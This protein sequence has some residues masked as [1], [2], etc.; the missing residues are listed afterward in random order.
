MFWPLYRSPISQ[1]R[2]FFATERLA[3]SPYSLASCQNEE[4][5]V[6][7]IHCLKPAYQTFKTA[8]FLVLI[9]TSGGFMPLKNMQNSVMTHDII[10]VLKN[11]PYN[12]TILFSLQFCSPIACL[13]RQ[14]L[15]KYLT[16]KWY[17]F[18]FS[19]LLLH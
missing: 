17:F 11:A 8:H 2:K 16:N 13:T 19:Y 18:F 15:F 4:T 1:K 6:S 9:K 12:Y 3:Y 5:S 14:K 10:N 7:F